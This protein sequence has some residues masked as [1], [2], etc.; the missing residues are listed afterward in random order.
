M[1]ASLEWHAFLLLSVGNE[2]K[3]LRTGEELDELQPSEV[4]IKLDV[5]TV[6]A[7]NVLNC[8][9]IVQACCTYYMGSLSRL[10][11]VM[12][13]SQECCAMV[14][15]YSKGLRLLSGTTSVQELLL[16]DLVGMGSTS[17]VGASIED[18]FVLLRL[19]SGNAV[20]LQADQDEGGLTLPYYFCWLMNILEGMDPCCTEFRHWMAHRAAQGAACGSGGHEQRQQDHGM[21]PVPGHSRLLCRR[22][23]HA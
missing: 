2:S 10:C 19:S 21:Q 1:D 17:I 4:D 23:Q 20:L 12:Q 22:Q 8:S 14:Q 9:R 7:G 13:W 11:S 6:H 5:P 15:V 3:V 18:P 16:K